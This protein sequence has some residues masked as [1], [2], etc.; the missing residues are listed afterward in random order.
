M[1][2]SPTCYWLSRPAPYHSANPPFELGGRRASRTLKRRNS[3][4]FIFETRGLATCPTLPW[5][6]AVGFEPAH[7]GS[8]REP[9]S[10]R[11]RYRSAHPTNKLMAEG[12]GFDPPHPFTDDICL[13][14]R[15][16]TG[17]LKEHG[18]R[19]GSRPASEGETLR[20]Q[21]VSWFCSPFP[22]AS[23]HNAQEMIGEI[24]NFQCL[25]RIVQIHIPMR[26]R[27]FVRTNGTREKLHSPY[28][29][30]ALRL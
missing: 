16:L 12:E 7:D 11:V 27:V 14:T 13:A 21:A 4:L 1:L 23:I 19:A 8:H 29:L 30:A 20:R 5:P 18:W 9:H 25:Q 6:E 15:S 22:R 26:L 17:L 24:D 2:G 3:T 10:K 28:S